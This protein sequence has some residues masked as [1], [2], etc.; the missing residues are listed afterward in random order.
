MKQM[1]DDGASEMVSAMAAWRSN[2][3]SN[4]QNRSAPGSFPSSAD[5]G[6]ARA[7]PRAPLVFMVD[8]DEA[9][10]SSVKL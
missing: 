2:L 8:D 4:A 6:P 1:S 10:R 5:T 3:K 7:A 9:V